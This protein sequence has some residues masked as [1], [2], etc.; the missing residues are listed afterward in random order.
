[1]VFW[2]IFYDSKNKTC[3]AHPSPTLTLAGMAL[4][5]KIF[6]VFSNLCLF[7]D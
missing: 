5:G 6:Q 4:G 1:M 7:C 2:Y 3:I